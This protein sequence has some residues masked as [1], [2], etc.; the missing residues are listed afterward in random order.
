MEQLTQQ[1]MG[2]RA[3]RMHRLAVDR[4]AA[5]LAGVQPVRNVTMGQVLGKCTHVQRR[6]AGQ[7]YTGGHPVILPK[8]R[9]HST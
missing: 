7:L 5:Q 2:P 1:I 4:P 8:P 6:M 3:D 9:E